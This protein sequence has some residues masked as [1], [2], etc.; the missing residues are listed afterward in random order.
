[1]Q[2]ETENPTE[3]SLG[4]QA[5][6]E[7]L[8]GCKRRMKA[9]VPSEKVKEELDRN[10]RD[11]TKSVRLP[12][13][14][15]GRVPRR[16][17]EARF[18]EEIESEVK[19]NLL[20]TSF[21]EVIDGN[22]L[23]VYSF[24]EFDQ[25]EF[26]PD[27]DLTYEAAFEVH[28]EFDLPK[29][30]GVEVDDSDR[31][32]AV[33][34]ADVD[35]ELE[36]LRRRLGELKP[37]AFE[38]GV[39]ADDYLSGSYVLYRD[40]AEVK[41]KQDVHFQPRSN[42]IDSFLVDDLEEQFKTW[43]LTAEGPIKIEVTVP[44]T[45]SDEVLHGQKVRLEFTA[46]HAF[47]QTLPEINDEFA[48]K[49]GEENVEKLKGS[50]RERLEKRRQEEENRAV[51]EKVLDQLAAATEMDVPEGLVRVQ[52][53]RQ[54][55]ELKHELLRQGVPE[56]EVDERIT[57][58][59]AEQ[60]GEEKE[61]A[62]AKVRLA[63]KKFFILEKVAEKEKI[64]ATEGDVSRYID[65]LSAQYGVSPA[66]LR[67]RLKADG[68]LSETRQ[69]LRHEKVRKYLREK[70]KRAGGETKDEAENSKEGGEGRENTHEDSQAEA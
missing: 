59:L 25:V 64:F 35:E 52:L 8:G 61:E 70:A 30:K 24:P 62:E 1:M 31:S 14:R 34:S 21:S 29:Y 66:D 50:L 56:A 55:R 51:E 45:F 7:E 12:G 39:Q 41:D 58:A 27:A 11:L 63:A 33:T 9:T 69:L 67:S 38:E 2:T 16:L 43:D 19:E 5:E 13:F 48:E 10:Y 36:A 37:V 17:L 23:K 54:Q 60:G 3:D 18:G 15:P 28:P 6:I 4:T 20:R 42:V 44:E 49:I 40:D 57:K 53:Q 65:E 46:E 68:G 22:N 26:A 32:A 47:R